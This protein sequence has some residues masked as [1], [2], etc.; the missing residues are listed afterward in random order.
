MDLLTFQRLLFELKNN[1]DKNQKLE[2]EKTYF[3]LIEQNVD[4]AAEL[5][6]Q[7]IEANNELSDFAIICLFNNVRKNVSSSVL[8]KTTGE[9]DAAHAYFVRLLHCLAQK[10]QRSLAEMIAGH[11]L[12]AAVQKRNF[13]ELNEF[14]KQTIN[15]ENIQLVLIAYQLVSHMAMIDLTILAPSYD[16]DF[17]NVLIQG[18][19][20]QEVKKLSIQ[21]L[22]SIMASNELSPEQ[23]KQIR[24]ICVGAFIST[25]NED[26]SEAQKLASSI[27]QLYRIEV[28]QDELQ[29]VLLLCGQVL[30]SQIDDDFKGQ[31][32]EIITQIVE[33][34]DGDDMPTMVSF[35]SEILF[36]YAISQASD[37]EWIAENEDVQNNLVQ[38]TVFCFEMQAQVFG[39]DFIVELMNH[40]A[41]KHTNLLCI[42]YRCVEHVCDEISNEQVIQIFNYCVESYQSSSPHQRYQSVSLLS[43]LFLRFDFLSKEYNDKVFNFAT[44]IT[45]DS[46]IK[47]QS[48]GLGAFLNYITK[49]NVKQLDTKSQILL[50]VAEN[51]YQSSSIY[52]KGLSLAVICILCESMPRQQTQPLIEQL[53]PQ[54]LQIYVQA[55]Q[56]I[57]EEQHLSQEQDQYISRIIE[58]F[59]F[60]VLCNYQIFNQ[61]QDNVISLIIQLLSL[62]IEYQFDEI[63]DQS[64]KS[65]RRIS[66]FFSFANHL[67]Q[68]AE[69]IK[70]V[71]ELKAIKADDEFELQQE[72]N[73]DYNALNY[74]KTFMLEFS[75]IIQNQANTL[76]PLYQQLF[77]FA[78][79]IHVIDEEPKYAKVKLLLFLIK[80]AKFTTP[81]E[82]EELIQ[83]Q[84]YELTSV[85]DSNS[86]NYYQFTVKY[87]TKLT[88]DINEIT[89]DYIEISQQTNDATHLVE[90][91]EIVSNLQNNVDDQTQ[92]EKYSFVDLDEQQIISKV[93][94]LKIDYEDFWV[95]CAAFWNIFFVKLQ[96]QALTLLDQ[97]LH[98][99]MAWANV[100]IEKADQSQLVRFN[101][102]IDICCSIIN[103]CKNYNMV[104]QI[105]D[106]IIIQFCN[107][108]DERKILLIESLSDLVI[109]YGYRQ[110]LNISLSE[111]KI[112]TLGQT[113]LLCNN[114]KHNMKTELAI[115][116]LQNQIETYTYTE[117]ESEDLNYLMLIFEQHDH[118]LLIQAII[119]QL[120]GSR[121]VWYTKQFSHQIE[122]K[123][124]LFIKANQNSIN[125]LSN[126]IVS[127]IV[128]WMNE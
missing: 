37:E 85:F 82:L 108:S 98:T 60:A 106:Q 97:Q 47:V 121:C 125:Q 25:L 73:T 72:F 52:C 45:K 21:G 78:K 94:D 49:I 35:D 12:V 95:C 112:N 100:D 32:V 118:K 117:L 62:G 59:S 6:V 27:E 3:K 55:I 69:L 17:I 71:S 20:I 50:N 2:L 24:G 53:V 63:V 19:Q 29:Q 8:Y 33:K 39:M 101:Q 93:A 128:W 15:N 74:K 36:K 31:M 9:D 54:L 5:L 1:K 44:E 34:L 41:H 120:F 16:I 119:P 14:L 83:E 28:E 57:Q 114:Q 81:E 13:F 67:N 115:L 124:K 77:S 11:A 84:L 107:V 123:L 43:E 30:N 91:V 96:D 65:L 64:L 110:K 103:A 122:K 70:Q 38:G 22:A 104:V 102:V 127:N 26:V 126:D 7:S 68:L 86:C 23:C 92:K 40:L 48:M 56:K 79:D 116:Q 109:V 46:V 4:N 99:M 42:L 18:T 61:I 88:I 10:P 80:I 111:D 89:H 105:V 113:L 51:G 66:K 90:L 58:F 76:A 75:H 87:M